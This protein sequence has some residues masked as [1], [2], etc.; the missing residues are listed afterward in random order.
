[1]CNRLTQKNKSANSN[2]SATDDPELTGVLSI[3]PQDILIYIIQFLCLYEVIGLG[4][5]SKW[6]KAFVRGRYGYDPFAGEFWPKL[7]MQGPR[8]S[9][10]SREDIL[11]SLAARAYR[12]IK[13]RNEDVLGEKYK[14]LQR[15]GVDLKL[16]A[17]IERL[18]KAHTVPSNDKMPFI[19]GN[20]LAE[21]TCGT[22]TIR[23][24]NFVCYANRTATSE[25]FKALGVDTTTFDYKTISHR[26]AE[27]RLINRAHMNLPMHYVVQLAQGTMTTGVTL[28][29]DKLCCVFCAC[30]LV[31]LGY[32]NVIA[33]WAAGKL[34]WYTFSPMVMFFKGNRVGMWGQEVEESFV[35]LPDDEKLRFLQL[36]VEQTST[37]SSIDPPE[38]TFGGTRFLNAPPTARTFSTGGKRQGR[39]DPPADKKLKVETA[40]PRCPKCGSAMVERTGATKFWGCSTYARTKCNGTLPIKR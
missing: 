18:S 9:V 3:L 16:T 7:G 36:L 21:V 27:M 31:S 37:I 38:N 19:K 14:S 2:S 1:M 28:A 35:S 4:R 33:G 40:A 5:V 32:Q 26:H 8:H 34:S 23:A 24:V 29:V 13:D 39:T 11:A 20:C 15:S 22:E 25:L 10:G 6:F 12:A 30:Q 17:R